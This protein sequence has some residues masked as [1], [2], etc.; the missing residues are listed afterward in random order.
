MAEK[1]YNAD[2]LRIL[3]GLE[4]V[5]LR[6]GMYIGSTGVKGLHHVLWEIVDN[7]VDEAANGYADEIT[8]KLWKDGSASVE[9]NG[10]GMPIDENKK[11]GMSGVEVIFTKLHAGGKFDTEN[12]AF[13]GGLHGVGAS[14]TN[15]LSE[16]LNVEVYRDTVYKMSFFSRYDEEKGKWLC[17][18]PEYP[19]ENTGE[20]TEKRGTFVRFMPDKEVFETVEWHYDVV[21]KRLKELAFLNKG[22]KINLIDERDLYRTVEVDDDVESDLG[23]E[24]EVQTMQELLPPREPVSFKYD[25]GLVDFVKYLNGDRTPLYKEPLYCSAVKDIQLKGA[26]LGK[27]KIEFSICHTKDD[28]ES[29]FS[30]VNNISTVEGGYHETGFHNGLLKVIN[31]YA[32]NNGF[33]KSKEQPFIADDI[34]EG[35]TAVLTVKMTGV[36][37]EGQTKTKL[38]N[39]EA[40]APVEQTVY[41]GLS[42]LVADKANK[43]LFDEIAKKAKF[44]A[45]DRIKH[46]AERDVAKAASEND[47]LNLVG[48]LASCSGKNPDQN[49]LFIVEG[50]SAGGTAKQARV[51]QYQS[52]LPLR[53]KPLNVQKKTA[54]QAL[55]NEEIKTMISAI[56]AGF[57]RSF[58]VEK[59]KYKKV[60]ILSDADQDGLH[61]RCILL[62]FFFKYMRDLVNA[63]YVYIGMPPLYKVYKRDVVEYAYD[64]EELDEKIKKVGKGYQIQRYKGLG[65]MSAE[66]LWETTM[67]PATRNLTQVTIE[68]AADAADVIEMLMGDKVEGRKEFLAQNA[69]F[70]KVDGFI[71]RVRFKPENDS[72][73]Y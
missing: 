11:A 35:L 48:K 33:L 71:D 58:E 46:R 28:T 65:E 6:P 21:F 37:F 8:V 27:I 56:G 66:Q 26:P 51:R 5:R 2:D 34:K 61:I 52:I 19:L 49:E 20:P 57:N 30:F 54:L 44:A 4:A 40:K 16:W 69:N 7:S 42:E 50:D 55:Q 59:T 1:S 39:P 32:R 24:G 25:G 62:T 14:V 60:I 10:R 41:E 70:N 68:N 64:D 45:D 9:D 36:E 38:G 12:Y 72:E 43:P 22:L 3:E 23:E 63:G 18:V 47:G 31:E 53:G 13:S 17:G 15:A 67:N 73:G 29:L